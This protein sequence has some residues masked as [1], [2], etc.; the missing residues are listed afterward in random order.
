MGASNGH[1]LGIYTSSC[2]DP[3]PTSPRYQTAG[4]SAQVL[5]LG[6]PP[7]KEPE[8]EGID[9]SKT[10]EEHF[11]GHTSASFRS[12]LLERIS[13]EE[14]PLRLIP[15][16]GS[17]G[18]LLVCFPSAFGSGPLSS[19]VY[20]FLFDLCVDPILHAEYPYRT[21]EKKNIEN[22]NFPG[23][24]ANKSAKL[25]RHLEATQIFLYVLKAQ[26]LEP[27]QEEKDHLFDR[28]SENYVSFIMRVPN[29]QK[30]T[31]FKLYP[32]CLSQAIYTIFQEAFPDS[33]HLFD[34]E[35]KDELVTT[36]FQWVTGII[37]PKGVWTRWNLGTLEENTIHGTIK[38]ALETEDEKL[39]CRK[40]LDKKLE[41][42]LEK[43]IMEY[44]NVLLPSPEEP[45][46]KKESHLIGFGPEFCRILFKIGGQSPLVSYYMKVHEM[47][48]NPKLP[49]SSIRMTQIYQWPA[50]EGQTYNEV[51]A[52]S[53]K[54]FAKNRAAHKIESKYIKEEIR[55]IQQ[56]NRE[57][58]RMFESF[59]EKAKQRPE[60]AMHDC[61][62]YLE[63]LREVQKKAA[64]SRT[65]SEVV[66]GAVASIPY[67]ACLPTLRRHY[68]EE[69]E[70]QEE[71]KSDDQKS[72]G[73]SWL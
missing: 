53:R 1:Q 58:N 48:R 12:R 4:A 24:K 71:K 46:G 65:P 10:R 7:Q 29:Y 17:P 52:E 2:P 38:R 64:I 59:K 8:S 27:N 23:F 68:E 43:L 26:K 61:R 13:S 18:V 57:H 50:T 49:Y 22:F 56:K 55:I 63:K 30:D 33:S 31:F 70:I 41:F 73:I 5:S 35:F 51:I 25:P 39:K 66:A 20:L 21:T 69:E 54:I 34:N 62:K 37:P 60:E 19:P 67:F 36:I 15:P 9:S 16:P 32:D 14:Q 40:I 6:S 47:G 3:V 42:D 28:I 45:M 44:R 72:L 11:P